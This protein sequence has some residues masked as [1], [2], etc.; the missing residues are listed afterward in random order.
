MT[1][2]RA[3]AL[4]EGNDHHRGKHMRKR[5]QSSLDIIDEKKEMT[6]IKMITLKKGT[7]PRIVNKKREMGPYHATPLA[8]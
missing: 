8:S 1:F 6:I 3:N 4:K 2:K 7:S 5:R